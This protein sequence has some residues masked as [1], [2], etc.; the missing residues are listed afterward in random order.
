M[1]VDFGF[2]QKKF[3]YLPVSSGVS[4]PFWMSVRIRILCFQLFLE[5][6]VDVNYF[7]KTINLCVQSN[8]VMVM[9]NLAI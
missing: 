2:Q 5:Y 7:G 4:L 6:P 3:C 9:G 1:S 8:R